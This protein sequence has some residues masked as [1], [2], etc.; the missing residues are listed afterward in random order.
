MNRYALLAMLQS[1]ILLLTSCDAL[2]VNSKISKC[3][4]PEALALT[5]TVIR[6]HPVMLYWFNGAPANFV[7]DLS[8]AATEMILT[9]GVDKEIGKTSC[10]ATFVFTRPSQEPTTDT[11]K[12]NLRTEYELQR[13]T[14]GQ[15]VSTVTELGLPSCL[16]L[17][18][19]EVTS[20][21]SNTTSPYRQYELGVRVYNGN[22]MPQNYVEA[23]KWFQKSADQGN[24]AA[25]YSL[26]YMYANGEGVAENDA[27]AVKW[28]RLAADQGVADAQHKLG[29]MYD[30][31]EGVPKSIVDA[32]F[33][34]NLAAAQGHADAETNKAIIEKQMTREQIA[35][36]QRR[37]AA[38]TPKK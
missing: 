36:A 16:K 4:H 32:Y 11:C 28:Y 3:D 29:V 22:G 38:W 6:A 8:L 2:G 17:T 20:L 10:L 5:A 37:S 25:Q 35:E 34:G 19:E 30:N 7:S 33:W 9:Q 27:E 24:A 18:Q 1:T 23:A 14:T 26:G 12:Y 13:D 15:L 21:I 31:G